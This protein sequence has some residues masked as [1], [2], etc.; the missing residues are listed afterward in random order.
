MSEHDTE[1]QQPEQP[2]EQLEPA[3]PLEATTPDLE[4]ED[5]ADADVDDVDEPAAPANEH[6]SPG[7]GYVAK[8]PTPDA[9]GTDEPEGA[10]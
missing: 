7:L 2:A 10:A 3:T 1:Q 9:A 8:F 4:L 6:D 5:Q